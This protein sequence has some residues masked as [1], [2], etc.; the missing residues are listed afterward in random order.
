MAVYENSEMIKAGNGSNMQEPGGAGGTQSDDADED[1]YTALEN[2]NREDYVY[3]NTPIGVPVQKPPAKEPKPKM[4]A[5]TVD[6]SGKE[7]YEIH[8]PR[9]LVSG[10]VYYENVSFGNPK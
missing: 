6:T 2:T 3:A 8:Q 4:A 9:A 10:S 5:A 1:Q 7:I